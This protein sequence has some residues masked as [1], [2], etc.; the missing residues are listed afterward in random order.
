MR[1]QIDAAVEALE[2]LAAR[3]PDSPG[4]WSLSRRGEVVELVLQHPSARNAVSVSMM[5]SFARC[6][7][8]LWQD[9]PGFVVLRS[10]PSSVFCAGG[11]LP[12]VSALLVEPDAARVM[13]T[14]FGAALDWV[15]QGPWVSFAAVEGAAI[16]GGAE[17]ALAADVVVMG[18]SAFLEFRQVPLGVVAG[19]GGARRLVARVGAARALEV[20]LGALRMDG[21]SS[22][23][24]GLCDVVDP[25]PRAWVDARVLAWSQRPPAARAALK[26]QITA[27]VAK[28]LVGEAEAFLSVWGA[29]A[30]LDALARWASRTER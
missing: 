25:D 20:M 4:V 14:V 12:E 27:A 13:T 7:R 17:L 28:D 5:A 24:A 10:E 22:L 23:A 11:Y 2:R 19:W 15:R 9:P 26:A 8:Q 18:P 6:M 1:E 16:G 29:S 21:P 30:H 3:Q